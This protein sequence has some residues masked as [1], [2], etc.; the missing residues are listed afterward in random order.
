M[1]GRS[2]GKFEDINADSRKIFMLD[3]F[4]GM[5]FEYQRGLSNSFGV[6]HILHLQPAQDNYGTYDFSANFSQGKVSTP[7]PHPHPPFCLQT[8]ACHLPTSHRLPASH[9]RSPNPPAAALAAESDA[10]QRGRAGALHPHRDA[11][12]HHAVP[13]SG[14]VHLLPHGSPRKDPCLLLSEQ[15]R[16]R[17]EPG[18]PPER[19]IR[20]EG[21]V[22]VQE[23]VAPGPVHTVLP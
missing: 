16:C 22:Q 15:R 17:T 3:S 23:G 9:S 20:Q 10:D 12:S 1:V 6:S 8:L 7:A 2:Q 19:R 14:P 18:A 5:R 21:E 4:E 13:V 11:Q